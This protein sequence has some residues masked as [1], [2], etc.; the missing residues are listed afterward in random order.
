MYKNSIYVIPVLSPSTQY[1]TG[2]PIDHAQWE[3]IATI[4]ISKGIFVIFDV[5][6]LGFG[7]GDTAED[8][9]PIR[10]FA[11]L[12]LTFMVAVSFTENFGIHDDPTGALILVAENTVNASNCA[13]QIESIISASYT[14]P[15]QQGSRIV[16]TV[17]NNECYRR[18]WNRT[19][20]EV[21]DHARAW[22]KKFYE[23]TR[24]KGFSKSW[25]FV[26]QQEGLFIYTAFPG[27]EAISSL[28]T[29]NF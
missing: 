18:E 24:I 2:V 7:T 21:Y 14:N 19:L 17:L 12:G 11:K 23:L 27:L 16:A 25:K 9:W 26:T 4:V 13:S 10:Y 6:Y 3:D 15:P 22:R 8:A 1:P 28:L 29:N 20:C 5:P